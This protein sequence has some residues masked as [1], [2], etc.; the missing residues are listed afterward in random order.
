[1][2]SEV[3]INE[4]QQKTGR[5]ALDISIAGEDYTVNFPLLMQDRRDPARTDRRTVT[6]QK[7]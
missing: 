2:V 1:M 7:L 5:K 3:V 4:S 6:W